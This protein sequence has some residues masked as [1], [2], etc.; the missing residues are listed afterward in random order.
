MGWE[1][2]LT[3]PFT[4]TYDVYKPD[5]YPTEGSNT[6]LETVKSY[7]YSPVAVE[8]AAWDSVSSKVSSPEIGEEGP[9]V[10]SIESAEP[11]EEPRSIQGKFRAAAERVKKL[12]VAGTLFW[13][14]SHRSS[15]NIG[16]CTVL[17]L[18]ILT[19]AFYG[20]T[21]NITCVAVHH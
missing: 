13:E 2:Y 8:K 21:Q 14:Q 6:M 11:K 15:T 18:Q 16:P 10:S 1:S 9:L 17:C 12:H 19:L 4:G 5:N 3:N 7:F 20:R